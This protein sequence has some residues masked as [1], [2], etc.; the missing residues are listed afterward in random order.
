MF[1][2]RFWI[3]EDSPSMN[4][5]VLFGRLVK[6]RREALGLTQSQ[7]AELAL[8]NEGRQGDISQIERGKGGNPKEETISAIR[9]TL[10]NISDEDIEKCRVKFPDQ[11]KKKR[12]RTIR[13]TSFGQRETLE[14]IDLYSRFFRRDRRRS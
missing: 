7:L 5:A 14:I 12:I 11:I 2:V 10:Y 9:H 8:G 6:A 1:G 4:F 3:D 13:I